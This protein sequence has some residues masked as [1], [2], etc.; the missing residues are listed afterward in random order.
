MSALTVWP[1]AKSSRYDGTC[2]LVVYKCG[3]CYKGPAWQ[4]SQV[5]KS[6]MSRSFHKVHWAT[7][8]K[9][10]IGT[11]TT[12]ECVVPNTYPPQHQHVTHHNVCLVKEPTSGT[13]S[14]VLALSA[15]FMHPWTEII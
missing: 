13:I 11:Y 1:D 3:P 7:M 2:V 8:Q 6:C 9:A 12:K 10:S 5:C 4:S 14:G 15:S